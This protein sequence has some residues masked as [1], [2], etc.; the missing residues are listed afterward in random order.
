MSLCSSISPKVA[1]IFQYYF[2][3]TA[4]TYKTFLTFL[5]STMG[6]H[7]FFLKFHKVKRNHIYKHELVILFILFSYISKIVGQ[8][9][10][11]II[12][13]TCTVGNTYTQITCTVGNTYTQV[14]HILFTGLLLCQLQVYLLL[15][16][17]VF[18]LKHLFKLP[19]HNIQ[20][21]TL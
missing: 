11:T 5:F 7:F 2:P 1:I 13:I 4:T 6:N 10:M 14:T 18:Y 21:S 15:W 9:V 8:L 17:L 16:G 12:Q 19:L 20:G 3:W